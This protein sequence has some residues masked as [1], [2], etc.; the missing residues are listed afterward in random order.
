MLPKFIEVETEDA[1]QYSVIWLHGLGADGNDFSD[2]PHMLKLPKGEVTR[3]VFPHAPMRPITLNGGMVMRGWYDLVELQD[4]EQD[5]IQGLE[6][7]SNLIKALIE[8]EKTFGVPAQKIFLGGFSQGGA[9]SLYLGLR[10]EE[11]LAGVI[12]LSAYLPPPKTV[13]VGSSKI[14][15]QTPVFMAHG[16]D[17]PMVPFP[18][19]DNSRQ[20]IEG[21]GYR[22]T[23]RT[24]PMEHSI[25]EAEIHDMTQFFVDCL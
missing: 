18:L 22:L 1:P 9:L 23:W 10:H 14:N 25:C 7:S 24:Y 20:L 4:T 6:E 15:R 13:F 21:M 12:A 11:R 5:D 17:D 16:L 19:A 8:R 3:F 2:F